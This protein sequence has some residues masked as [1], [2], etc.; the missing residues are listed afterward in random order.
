VTSYEVINLST[1]TIGVVL[2]GGSN[3]AFVWR[4]T[5]SRK[6]ILVPIEAQI[7]FPGNHVVGVHPLLDSEAFCRDR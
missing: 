4:Q 2:I 1:H 3:D 5:V 7:E 6:S